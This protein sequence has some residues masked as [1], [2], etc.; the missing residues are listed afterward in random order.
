M[1]PE[2][3]QLKCASCTADSS[4]QVQASFSQQDNSNPSAQEVQLAANGEKSSSPSIQQVAATGFSG[5]STSLP[6]LNQIQQSFGV[7]LAG[8]QAYIGG[9]AATACQ[10]MGAAAYAN[11][12]QIAFNS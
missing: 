5:S 2:P 3:L 8:V 4:V 11:G 7:N 10:Q 12:N 6:H 9:S 1:N